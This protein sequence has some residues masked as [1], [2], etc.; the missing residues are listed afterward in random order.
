MATP[1]EFDADGFSNNLFSDLAPLLALFGEEIIA[2]FFSMSMGWADNFLLAMGPVGIITIVLSAIRIGGS[3]W[4]KRLVGRGRETQA[5]AEQELLSSTSSSV[6]ELWNGQQII[7]LIGEPKGVMTVV[8]SSDGTINTLPQ[9]FKKGIIKNKRN[10]VK[11][12]D[13]ARA[14]HRE[15]D[16]SYIALAL[17]TNLTLNTQSAPAKKSEM[18]FLAGI[19]ICLQAIAIVY[20]GLATYYFKWSKGEIPVVDYGYPCFAAGTVCLTIG[21]ILCG[22]I[23]E[24][25]TQEIE[26]VLTEESKNEGRR[27]LCLQEAS[28]IG[29][30]NIPSC[31]IFLAEGDGILRTSRK[32]YSKYGPSWT[33]AAAPT[34]LALSGYIVQ[35][36]GL[37]TLHW[38]ATILQLAVTVVM[39]GVRAWARRCLAWNPETSD[40][41]LQGHEMAWLAL[42]LRSE[43][44]MKKDDPKNQ[45]RWF[46]Y[47]IP[48]R[49]TKSGRKKS[50]DDYKRLFFW[51]IISDQT[52]ETD[53][54]CSA[55]F[56]DKKA[57]P[58]PTVD[59]YARRKAR[60]L[61]DKLLSNVTGPLKLHI[62]F[63]KGVSLKP[64]DPRSPHVTSPS[65]VYANI[66]SRI[67]KSNTTAGDRD[68]EEAASALCRVIENVMAVFCNTNGIVWKQ[69]IQALVD[70][71]D[72]NEPLQAC[73]EFDIREGCVSEYHD[74][75]KTKR[76]FTMALQRSPH[77]PWV[78]SNR[79]QLQA[80]ISLS[81]YTNEFRRMCVNDQ[82]DA[83]EKVSEWVPDGNDGCFQRIIGSGTHVEAESLAQQIQMWLERRVQRSTLSAMRGF[84]SQ[85]KAAW[86]GKEEQ[87]RRPVKKATSAS[88][89]GMFLSSCSEGPPTPQ[90]RLKELWISERPQVTE[91]FEYAQELFS[92]FMLA[93]ASQIDR[94]NGKTLEVYRKGEGSERLFENSV[95]RSIAEI[96]IGEKLAASMDEAYVLIIPAF[97]KHKLLPTP[98]GPQSPAC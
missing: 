87:P 41:T 45:H 19:G 20:P 70:S 3:G 58:S 90:R 15:E 14:R 11:N 68:S 83:A 82:K 60:Y 43:A 23:I 54:V 16:N 61:S 63:R 69:S 48:C 56:V 25:A 21:V 92:I 64:V 39:T 75:D 65:E 5:V 93:L 7:R 33:R 77:Q 79:S 78:V 85:V 37:R 95:F 59:A 29:D 46:N 2:Q 42:L 30:Q 40:L 96:V 32:G 8:I 86:V 36:V 97:A 80:A 44:E 81:F 71:G 55:A 22:H 27:I 66:A 26:F 98:P 91:A 57:Q 88:Y 28:T 76:S 35:F 51:E 13:G 49:R 52:E 53:G 12:G 4:L 18:W 38:S 74:S 34:F 67:G 9:A 1:G 17:P 84:P 47:L 62:E 72:Q 94:V 10:R 73:C 31:A 24:G 50:V 6:C 89:L